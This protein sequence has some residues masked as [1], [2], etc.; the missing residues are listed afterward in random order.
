MKKNIPFIVGIIAFFSFPFA[1]VSQTIE[2]NFD[3]ND[4]QFINSKL[5][6]FNT[7]PTFNEMFESS[8]SPVSIVDACAI[9]PPPFDT[10]NDFKIISFTP[11]PNLVQKSAEL[12]PATM[13]FP[14]GTIANFYHLYEYEDGSYNPDA[15]VFAVGCGTQDVETSV[16]G[17]ANVIREQYC[18]KDPRVQ[19]DDASANPN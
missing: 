19:L 17:R 4:A 14:G 11:Q 3:I 13:R 6:G 7:G 16:F 10:L 18:K 9:L 1:T 15:P 2:L 5:S 8:D 12:K